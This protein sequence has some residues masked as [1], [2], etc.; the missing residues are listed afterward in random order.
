M[1]RVPSKE[2][3]DLMDSTLG[4]ADNGRCCSTDCGNCLSHGGHFFF[5]SAVLQDGMLTASKEKHP[6]KRIV[7]E[8]PRNR[9][10]N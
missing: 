5:S 2:A 6:S 4:F 1:F 9:I 8:R 10:Y 7:S 3:E